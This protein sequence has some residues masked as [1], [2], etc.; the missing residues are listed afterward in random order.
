[1]DIAAVLRR[2]LELIDLEVY[3]E[4]ELVPPLL[5]PWGYKK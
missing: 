3:L 5:L 1:M 4:L 2:Q